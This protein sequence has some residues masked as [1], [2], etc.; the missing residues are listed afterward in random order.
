[1][2][3]KKNSLYTLILAAMAGVL[4]VGCASREENPLGGGTNVSVDIPAGKGEDAASTVNVDANTGMGRYVEKNVLSFDSYGNISFSETADGQ[5]VIF[6]KNA[7]KY[8]STDHGENWELENLDWL[9]KISEGNYVNK[10]A[11]S[12]DGA[13]ALSYFPLIEEASEQEGTEG[14]KGLVS[15]DVELDTHYLLVA[16]DGTQMEIDMGIS[17]DE[18]VQDFCFSEMGR[19]FAG[20]RK[21]RIYEINTADGSCKEIASLENGALYM[22]YC[23]NGILLCASHEKVYL[24]NITD[25]TFLEDEALQEFILEN[26]KSIEDYG[27]GY[28]AYLFGGEENIVYLASEKGLYRH[29][30]GGGT[31]EQVID[32]NLSAFGDP[33][34][35]VKGALFLEGQE[36]LVLFSDGKIMKF[37]YDATIS[38]VPNDK[39]VVYSLEDNDT[40]RQAISAYQMANPDMYVSYEIGLEEDGVTRDDALK[41]LS[42]GLLNGSGPDVLVLDQMPFDSYIDKGVLLD[43]SNV[44]E[45]LDGEDGLFMNLLEPLY[46]DGSLYMMPAEFQLPMLAG[47]QND[48]QNATDYQG[49]ADMAE[50]VRAKK[51][52]ADLIFKSS[53]SGI[54]KTF[55]MVCEPSWKRE[56]GELDEE[57]LRAFLQ[58]TKRIY[59]AQMN[60][61]PQERIE[62]YQSLN[63]RYL[64]N[65]GCEYE[66]SVYFYLMGDSNYISGGVEALCGT[67]KDIDSFSGIFSASKVKGYEDTHI[68]RMDGQSRNVYCPMTLAGINAATKNSEKSV[69]FLRTLLGQE[70]Q[71]MTHKGYP[72]NK[73]AFEKGLE[74][75][76]E[77]HITEE[78]AYMTYA[79]SDE[80]GKVFTWD[81]YW[82]DGKQQRQLRDWIKESDTPYL[83]DVMLEEAVCREGAKYLN[84]S[85]GLDAAMKA[86][87]DS[88]AI[89]LSE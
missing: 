4:A 8:V 62:N 51:P 34:H 59:D 79:M 67:V 35:I 60:G 54:L 42:T 47:H 81:I 72:V 58:Q 61:T 37:T 75:P 38:A 73:T 40:I 7:G 45:G 39:L 71:Q 11:V 33:S 5:L 66:D 44:A 15:H 2:K 24:Y 83:P 19:L 89:Y 64:K 56:N 6:D 49:I 43:I 30:I 77:H 68:R 55:F 28:N 1:M 78:G 65:F 10:T 69:L 26:Y 3:K 23:R 17:E 76:D 63:G 16:P 48:V 25:G 41:K 46:T 84:G 80:E 74:K 13:F 36:F 12:N 18:D 21:G 82:P 14:A 87:L 86:I 32:G 85:Q 9:N 20:T 31:V 57:S 27:S 22:G 29:V 50:A 70:V 52:T 53:E 88:V